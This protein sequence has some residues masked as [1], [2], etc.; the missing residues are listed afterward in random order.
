MRIGFAWRSGSRL[1]LRPLMAG[2]IA[3]AALFPTGGLAAS[4]VPV[5]V[6]RGGDAVPLPRLNPNRQ[7]PSAIESVITDEEANEAAAYEDSEQSQ[8]G[9]P[10]AANEVP[11]PTPRQDSDAILGSAGLNVALRL[12]A[13]GDPAAAMVAAYALPN[14]TDIKIVEWLV[15]VSGDKQVPSARIAEIKQ[16]LSDWPGQGLLQL[17]YEQALV[18]ERP[19][20]AELIKALGG[21]TPT[22][23]DA[24][25]LLAR[26]F[27][28]AGRKSDAAK[29]IGRYW[30]EENLT[31]SIEKAVLKEFSGLLTSAD[32]KARMDRLLYAERSAGA[33]RAAA[34][35]DENQRALAN[36]VA[37][38]IKRKSSAR[39]SLDKLTSAVQKDPV[40]V[41][42]RIQGL[43]RANKIKRAAELMIA[44]PRD[45]KVLVDPDAWWIERR[46][47]S[48]AVLDEGDAKRAYEIAA[49]HAARSSALRAEA[50]FHAGWYALRYLHDPATAGRHF[51]NIAAIST[52]PL[53]LSRAEYWLG[54]A[55]AAGDDAE[56]AKLHFTR[57][58]GFP[59]T[60]YG[61]LASA[62]LGRSHLAIARPPPA[63][64]AARERFA[65]RELVQ[66][67]QHL[68][69]AGETEH[70]D[71]FYRH[72]AETLTDPAEV[73]LLAAMAEDNDEDQIA[74]QVGIL[75]AG[76]GLPVD[77]LA[78]PISAI[79]TSA[80]TL[81]VERS[82]VYAIARQ[83]SRFNTRAV[84]GAGARGLLQLM[85]AT[86]K[87]TARLIG[88]SYSRDRL[89]SD[90]AYNATLGAAHLGALIDRFGG[91][92]VMTFAAY[93]AGASRVAEWIQSHGD[94]R[95]PKVDVVDWIELIPFTETRNYVQRAMENLQV[96]RTRLESQAL[97]I[98]TD[99]TRGGAR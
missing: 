17:R 5:P 78:F 67:I 53:S 68:T 35:L 56:A 15:A 93:N 61:Q 83:E 72:L 81:T 54:R 34:H 18:R 29:L 41:Y 42:S 75:A 57:A 39:K 24:T 22:S 71:L 58:A 2:A 91:S 23:N 79:P 69:A 99:L 66:V 40:V 50:E 52:R 89:T 38:V 55:A 51:A 73:G 77:S 11:T 25:I 74:L 70:V 90:P 87:E 96:Y 76:N 31:P 26:A 1:P 44:A 14:R 82:I 88:V 59:T 45:P 37:A 65:A 92:Y 4:D 97:V 6:L 13:N 9:E 64:A 43:R 46:L 86:A 20:S 33:L 94:P 3:A 10:L 63:D 47:V 16:K 95:D 30:R 32:H 80:D 27:V 49:G 98:E 85:P 62:R 8:A 19:P 28:D 48:R 84:S 36:A 7:G 60:F 12:L 21:T